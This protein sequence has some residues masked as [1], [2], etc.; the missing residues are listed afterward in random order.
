MMI[1]IIIINA[2][3]VAEFGLLPLLL[4]KWT[5]QHVTWRDYSSKLPS[6]SSLIQFCFYWPCWLFLITIEAVYYAKIQKWLNIFGLPCYS[7]LNMIRCFWPLICARPQREKKKK[8][9][10]CCGP[11]ISRL[12]QTEPAQTALCGRLVGTRL[13]NSFHMASSWPAGADITNTY[14]NESSLLHYLGPRRAQE[15]SRFAE[16]TWLTQS[17]DLFKGPVLEGTCIFTCVLFSLFKLHYCNESASACLPPIVSFCPFLFTSKQIAS[18]EKNS[19]QGLVFMSVV[20]IKM[21]RQGFPSLK[22][23]GQVSKRCQRCVTLLQT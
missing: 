22:K 6:D 5:I 20:K 11:V 10:F 16:E 1:M 4:L 12:S 8:H 13:A 19:R 7:W 17:C 15:T 21:K 23:G 18:F 3:V 2:V 14:H 9:L